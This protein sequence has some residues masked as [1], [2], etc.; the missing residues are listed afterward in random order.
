[1]TTGCIYKVDGTR[2]AYYN[3]RHNNIS[4]KLYIPLGDKYATSL[5]VLSASNFQISPLFFSLNKINPP[6]ILYCGGVY[7]FMYSM[8]ALTISNV[9][10]SVDFVSQ[11]LNYHLSFG[12]RKVNC[13]RVASTINNNRHCNGGRHNNNINQTDTTAIA[14]SK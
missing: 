9:R 11:M 7:V 5:R 4:F 6:L 8:H 3:I 13:C 10:K 2:R 12:H 1:M 14:A